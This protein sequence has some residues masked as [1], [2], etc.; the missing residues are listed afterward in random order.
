M[1]DGTVDPIN[2]HALHRQALHIYGVLVCGVLVYLFQINL[3]Q[4]CIRIH[5][6]DRLLCTTVI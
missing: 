2:V 1:L 4:Y 5:L 3:S 6:C